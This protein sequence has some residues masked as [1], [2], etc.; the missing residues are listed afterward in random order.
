MDA[1]DASLASLLIGC[2][3]HRSRPHSIALGESGFL[4]CDDVVVPVKWRPA[5]RATFDFYR[6]NYGSV[7]L[8]FECKMLVAV[9][10]R[11]PVCQAA[12]RAA[13]RSS[14]YYGKVCRILCD[15]TDY[16]DM[17]DMSY[18]DSVFSRPV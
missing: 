7:A 14:R 13:V 6:G 16:E 18:C 17:T 2:F 8:S 5:E 1:H 12:V 11:W 10:L 3:S 15:V 9:F 4:L